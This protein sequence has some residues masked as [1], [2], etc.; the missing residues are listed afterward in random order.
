[1]LLAD[2]P[3]PWGWPE[4]RRDS[5][6]LR[7]LVKAPVLVIGLGLVVTGCSPVKMGAAAIVGNQRITI[8]TLDTEAAN[9]SRAAAQ[10]PDAVHLSTTQI[11]QDALTWLIRFQIN[12]ELARQYGITVSVAQEQ[13]A[14]ARVYAKAKSDAATAGMRNISLTLVMV[15]NGIPP[16]LESELARTEAI[17]AQFSERANGGRLPTTNSAETAVTAKLDEARCVAAKTLNIVVNPQFGRLDYTQYAVVSAPGTASRDEGP[18][19]ATS[20]SGLAP[21]C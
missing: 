2:L 1:L 19:Q 6:V 18:A 14:L 9:L 3:L 12:E 15:M 4:S 20:E 21:T 10:F 5:A 8:A 7:R 13:A 11:T 16:N 17:E